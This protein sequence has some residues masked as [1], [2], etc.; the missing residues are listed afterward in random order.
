MII[1]R[2]TIADAAEILA[3][4]KLAYQSEAELY[5]DF[6]IPPLTQTLDE[7]I[8]S[9]ARN[10]IL[11]ATEEG[12]IVGSMNGRMSKGCCLVGRLMVHP[13]LQ[14]KGVGTRL[15]GALE[16]EF[17]DAAA[18]RLFTGEK[19][20]R[21]IG[22]YQRLGYRIYERKETPGSFAIVFMEKLPSL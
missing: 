4:Q 7:L 3:L 22:L 13:E 5:N 17:A 14:G 9:F 19:S 15:M 10:T 20:E 8:E 12:R 2:A 6:S 11:K 1:D 18:F 16:Q 21:N